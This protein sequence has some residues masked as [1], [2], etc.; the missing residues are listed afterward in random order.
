MP[1][2]AK[3]AR[4]K[5]HPCV[6]PPLPKRTHSINLWLSNPL[7]QHRSPSCRNRCC[8]PT[9][10]PTASTC[11]SLKKIPFSRQTWTCLTSTLC[12]RLRI[13]RSVQHHLQSH[14]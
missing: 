11:M 12:N 2:S 8:H 5:D 1:A 9:T 14:R 10:S 6:Q 3:L 7:L 4:L 13:L